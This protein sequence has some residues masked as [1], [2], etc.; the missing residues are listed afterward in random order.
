[1]AMAIIQMD[2]FY[3][4]V[5]LLHKIRMKFWGFQHFYYLLNQEQ[6][7]LVS[8]DVSPRSYSIKI[9]NQNPTDRE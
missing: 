6:S 1:M 3:L 8:S 9:T 7:S 4:Y 5:H 2:V